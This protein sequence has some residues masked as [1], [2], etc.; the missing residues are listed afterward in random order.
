MLENTNFV[1]MKLTLKILNWVFMISLGTEILLHIYNPFIRKNAIE[2]YELYPNKSYTIKGIPNTIDMENDITIS[3]NSLGFRGSE[4]NEKQT[5][6]IICMGSSTTECP[7]LTDGTDWPTQLFKTL[8]KKDEHIWLNNAGTAG[9]I[10]SKYLKF[11]KTNVLPLKPRFVILMCGLDNIKLAPIEETP[12]EELTLSERTY[13]F[14]QIPKTISAILFGQHIP[15]PQDMLYHQALD[16]KTNPTL[17]MSDSAILQRIAREQPMLE[18]Y[19]NNLQQLADAC[20][21]NQIKLI[22]VSQAI[23]FGDEKDVVTNIDLGTLKTGA[24]NG[25]AKSLLLKQYNKTSFD[26]ATE[27]K[28]PFIN[29]S[30]R[31]P[32]DS[33]FFYDG[34][35][36]TKE[37]AEFVSEI[38]YDEIKDLVTK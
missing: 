18:L 20:K 35:H 10:S 16:L 19:K 15:R 7:Y 14:L 23:L 17:E 6:R 24:I 37:G 4:P 36:F 12:I 22:L 2:T 28:L 33:R 34:Y 9:L 38:I 1:V 5:N 25:K 30:A 31:L 32:K 11:F 8:E 3:T 21:A 27:N 13:Q 26:I 29:V